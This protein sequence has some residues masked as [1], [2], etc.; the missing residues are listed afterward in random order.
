MN[1]PL[2]A[3][4]DLL[5][6][7]AASKH[8][9][10]YFFGAGT[11]YLALCIARAYRDFSRTLHGIRGQSDVSSG[12]RQYLHASL[13]SLPTELTVVDQDSF[14]A[15]HK[16]VCAG[17]VSRFRASGFD[18]VHVGQAQKWLNMAL[19]YAFIF[20][21]SSLPGYSKFFGLCHVPID[22]IIL[23]SKP[24]AEAPAFSSAWSRIDDYGQYLKFQHWVR[25]QFPGQSPLA[26]E[27]VAW[28]AAQHE[29]S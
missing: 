24:F 28:A 15:W 11:D 14:D 10:L 19:K 22:N 1:S 7:Q 17:L 5:T 26:V 20:G 4:H 2:S 29:A 27:F 18:H 6:P 8:L 23:K 21:E 3:P 13:K 9:L 25:A 12:A 16:T